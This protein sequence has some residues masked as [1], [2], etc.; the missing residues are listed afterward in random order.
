[1]YCGILTTV[2]SSSLQSTLQLLSHHHHYHHQPNHQNAS[3]ARLPPP[4]HLHDRGVQDRARSRLHKALH[5]RRPAAFLRQRLLPPDPR[6][7]HLHRRA[8]PG[9]D[10]ARGRAARAPVCAVCRRADC[11][12]DGG[13]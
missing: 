13:L 5:R 12:E 2:H 6:H 3:L 4:D 11:G 10:R 8:A 9:V 1:M 7:G